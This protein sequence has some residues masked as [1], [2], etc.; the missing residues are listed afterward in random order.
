LSKNIDL[1]KAE[2][3]RQSIMKAKKMEPAQM[4]PKTQ[5]ALLREILMDDNQVIGLNP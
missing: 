2:K 5:L 3:Q 4:D 1:I